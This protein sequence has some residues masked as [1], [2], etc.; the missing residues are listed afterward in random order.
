MRYILE[1]EEAARR[2]DANGTKKY[3]AGADWRRKD[4]V[5]A[6][7]QE[8][9]R[10]RWLMSGAATSYYIYIPWWQTFKR[11]QVTSSNCIQRVFFS[12]AGSFPHPLRSVKVRSRSAQVKQISVCLDVTNIAGRTVLCT[13]TNPVWTLQS[14]NPCAA[15]QRRRTSNKTERTNSR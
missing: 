6:D 13:G 12:F 2:E 3:G 11:L 5:N 1:L 9:L 4:G 10:R 8:S 15:L 14:Q 7:G